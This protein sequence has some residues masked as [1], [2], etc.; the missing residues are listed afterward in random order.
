MTVRLTIIRFIGA[1]VAGN[2]ALL[3]AYPPAA[4]GFPLKAALDKSTVT[5]LHNYGRQLLN[6]NKVTEAL[7]I[8]ELNFKKF[9][10]A[11]PTSANLMRGHFAKGYLK[12][13]TG[14]CQ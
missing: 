11:W 14:I 2:T 1:R 10:G 9:N 3:N 7:E 6:E 5:E 12:K 4:F 8:F 13:S